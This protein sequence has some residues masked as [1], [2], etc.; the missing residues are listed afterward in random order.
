MSQFSPKGS[1]AAGVL[2]EPLR[3]PAGN[4]PQPGRR[5]WFLA[6]ALAAWLIGAPLAVADAGAVPGLMGPGEAQY[7]RGAHFVREGDLP[8]ARVQLDEAVLEAP[9]SPKILRLYAE[10]LVLSGEAG[11]AQEILRRLEAIEPLGASFEYVIALAS[12]R[13]GDW[14]A[15]R[16]RL[17]VMASAAPEP[18]SAY[19]YLGAA[20]QELGDFDAA[21]RAF[22]QALGADPSLAGTV[23]YRRGVLALQRGLYPEAA[24]QF[25]TVLD[26]L[27]GTPLASSASAYLA[28]VRR[29]D[30]RPWE[31][32]AR[33]GLGYDSNINLASGD[34]SFVSSGEEGWRAVVAAGGSYDFGDD[35]L[36]LQ[37]GQTLY[38]HFY[39]E[40]GRFDQQTSS[41]W[42]RGQI[43]LSDVL[44]ADLR[45]GFEFA[46]ADWNDYRSSQNLEPGL[47][48]E[49]SAGLAARASFRF[50]DRTYHSPLSP[51]A[52]AVGLDRNGTV[53]YAG[54]D[55][56]YI[57]PSPNAEAENWLRVGYRY[58]HEDTKGSQFLSSGHQPVVTLA[59]QLPWQLQSILDLRLEWRDYEVASFKSLSSGPRR[60]RI[61]ILRAGLERP[62]GDHASLEV[63]YRYTDR[64]SNVD[65]FVY[66]RHE[67]SFL[68]TYR[69]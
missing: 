55:F 65:F 42:A 68:G 36:G 18:G 69:Y 63:S 2:S 35:E 30:P 6:G 15:A 21:E 10:V 59:V 3:V 61:A 31:V 5:A 64:N 26:R 23:A 57:L 51:A 24:S 50:E 4:A 12:F 7:Q 38:G 58:R 45:Y 8:A 17:G 41:T 9:D 49:I 43:A 34:D 22:S 20:H 14:E 28:E 13:A 67:I 25:E 47:T 54:G 39:T 1:G 16:D 56:F 44:Q 48:W 32:F 40:D 11:R 33:V 27:P 62:L 46:W 60:D 52:V 37:V 29:L 66:D 53:E 19:L